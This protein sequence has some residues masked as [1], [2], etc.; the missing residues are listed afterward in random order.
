MACWARAAIP[1]FHKQLAKL[2]R[3]IVGML[4]LLAVYF[5]LDEARIEA[6]VANLLAEMM[7]DGAW[8]CRRGRRPGAH[9]QLLSHHLQRPRRP[10]RLYRVAPGRAVQR[11]HRRRT[12]RPGVHVGTQALSLRQDRPDHPYQ[13]H[14]L[15][16]SV[17]LV[18][19]RAARAELFC[20][21]RRAPGPAAAGRHRPA[22]HRQG[23]DGLWPVQHKHSGRVFFDMEK[24][25]GPSR[26]NTLRAL[27]V[28][29]WW[30]DADSVPDTSPR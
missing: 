23:K 6:L 30:Q 9:P 29:Q 18:L 7:P 5:E 10:A 16:L 27:R 14:L 15:L 1:K 11:N 4:L 20:P 24:T 8:N 2:D 3:C 21:Q 12:E 13:F 19:R 26:W 17:P 28:L 25:G 22:K